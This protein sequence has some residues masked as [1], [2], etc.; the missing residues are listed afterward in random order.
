MKYRFLGNTGLR[1]S[2]LCLGTMT[3][4][5]G[6]FGI[7]EVEQEG[8]TALVKRAMEGG[9]NF[10]DTADIYCRGQSETLLGGALKE[11]GVDRDSVVIATKVRGAMS[12]A[13]TVYPLDQLSILLGRLVELSTVT[14][15]E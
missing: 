6:F 14:Q 3:F 2:E 12:D 5:E 7:G 9:I 1:V 13:A 8:A 4:G 10:F 15:G 11:L